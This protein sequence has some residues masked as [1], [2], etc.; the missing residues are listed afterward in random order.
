MNDS[1]QQVWTR[2][3]ETREDQ[4]GVLQELVRISEQGEE[5]IQ[6][7]VADTLKEHGLDVEVIRYDPLALSTRREF[8]DQSTVEPIEHVTVVGKLPGTAGERS[9]LL[10]AQGDTMPVNGTESWQRSPFDGKIENGR[11]YG[12]GVSDDLSGLAA[13]TTAVETILAAGLKP[14]GD[15]IIASTPSKL[16]ARG[17]IAALEQGY[18]ADGVLY[19]H[20]AETGAGLNEIKEATS[21]L[22]SFR[23]T[24]PG[25]LPDTSEP[26]HTAFHHI[27]VDPIDK[28]WLIYQA[29]KALDERRGQA[30]HHPALDEAIGR[31]T[32]L[33]IAYIH[34]GQ[35]NKLIRVSPECILAGSLSMPP[36]E[37]VADVQAQ[38]TQAIE[39]A[40]NSDDWL[41]EHPPRIEWLVGIP[42]AEVPIDHPLYQATSQA[43]TD[44]TGR[45][46]RPNPLHTTSDIRNPML[47]GNMPTLG[48]GPKGGDLTQNGSHDEWVDVEEYIQTIKVLGAVILDWCGS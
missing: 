27:A 13:M 7:R 16:R 17:I 33:H 34:C 14:R 39:D 28:A 12:W 18:E 5:A 44:V 6:Q 36:G 9:L 29:L 32:N 1:K 41:K 43:I 8:A 48:L 45:V 19:V 21:G 30:V 3:D 35:A 37:V 31:S 26:G 22:L 15:L 42:G 2:I 25:R 46:P 24:V 4:I 47:F 38:V 20:P 23:I 11:L 10:F 40:A